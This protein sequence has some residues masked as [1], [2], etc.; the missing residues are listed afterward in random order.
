SGSPYLSLR[1]ANDRF[2]FRIGKEYIDLGRVVKDVWHQYVF[3]IKHATGSGGFVDVWQNGEKVISKT[4]KSSDSAIQPNWKLGIYKP[5]WE[6]RSTSTS[7]RIIY[8][9]NV[10]IGNRNASYEEMLPSRSQVSD[11]NKNLPTGPVD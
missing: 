10:K 4:G 7:K 5:T 11:P 6:K 9:D 1:V 2:Q 3:H 8:Y